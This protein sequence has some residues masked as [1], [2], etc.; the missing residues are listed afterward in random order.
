L[1]YTI[2][3]GCKGPSGE[4]LALAATQSGQIAVQDASKPTSGLWWSLIYDNGTRNFAM[5][6]MLS[7]ESGKP[8]ALA[9]AGAAITA[10]EV[11]LTLKPVSEGLGQLNTWSVEPGGTA[12][13]VR[14]ALSAALSLGVAGDG[15]WA[16]GSA[17]IAYYGSGAGV[18][19][20]IWTFQDTGGNSYPWTYTFAPASAPG[21]LLT[22]DENGGSGPLTVQYPRGDTASSLQLWNATY[23]IEGTTPIGAVFAN[24]ELSMIVRATPPGGGALICA[25]AA[26]PD[27]W[28]GWYTGPGPDT[29]LTAIHSSAEPGLYWNVSGNAPTGNPVISSPWQGGQQNELWVM[30]YVPQQVP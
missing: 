14:P 7:V 24:Q 21:L 4:T 22:A 5:V 11:A 29:N 3:P 19:N 16:P 26:A 12:L 10:G 13:T 15:P 18:S 8:A 17:V 23:H 25:D 20:Q 9:L 30:T 2:T 28:D 1:A 27:A 6:N